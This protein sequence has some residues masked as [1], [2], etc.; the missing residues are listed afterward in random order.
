MTNHTRRE[1]HASTPD[2][3]TLGGVG[4]HE[5]QGGGMEAVQDPSGE[6]TQIR[7]HTP[8]S[9]SGHYNA[10]AREGAQ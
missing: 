7:P 3:G 4:G 9:R 6:G 5:P 8:D 10:G 2:G 1:S